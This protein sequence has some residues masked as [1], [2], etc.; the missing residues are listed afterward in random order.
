MTTAAPSAG[1]GSTTEEGQKPADVFVVFGITGDLAK[2]M[3]FRSLYRLEQRGLLDCPIVGVAVDDWTVDQ[4]MER[5]RESIVGTGE[6]IDETVFDRFADAALVRRRRLRRRRDLRAGRARRSRAPKTPGLLPR[7]PAVPLRP[8]RQGAR[9]GRADE[10]RP[11]RRRE[12][13]RARPDVG[14]RARGR[15]APVHRRVAALP[16]RPLPREDGARGDPLP[17]VRELDARADL[18]PELRRVRPDHDGRGLRGRGPRPLLRPGRRAARRR[19]Q[20]PDAGRRRLRDGG[21]LRAA[22]RRR[23]R[24]PRSRSSA[25]SWRPTRRTTCAGQYDG[26][27]DIDGVAAGLDDRDLRRAAARDRELALGRRAVLHPHGQAAPGD[28]DRAPAR[29]QARRRGSASSMRHGRPEPNQLVVKLDPSTGDQAHPRRA[30][31]RSGR[32][33]ADRARHGVRARRAARARRPYEVLL[34]AAMVGDSTRFTRQDGVE[35]TWRIMQP[36]LDAPPPVHPYAP[37][38]WGPKEADEARRRPRPLARAVDRVMTETAAKERSPR[39][40]RRR[41]RSRRSPT[42]RSC[43]TAT[44][45]R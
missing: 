22:T 8:G 15:A 41:R 37:G 38:S 7:D 42:T 18:E 24:T 5:A 36:L 19:R 34:H 9:R 1:R 6:P 2:V 35:E 40:R 30:P 14:A 11:R 3:T 25:R 27:L 23:S 4:L 32:D 39:A 28:P 20:P 26:Y 43:P 44:R 13:V 16:D 45:A 29:L 12:A 17:A 10:D 31:R 21:A 33:R